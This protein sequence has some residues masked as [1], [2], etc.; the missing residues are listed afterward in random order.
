MQSNITVLSLILVTVLGLLINV[1]SNFL[2]DLLKYYHLIPEYTELKNIKPFLLWVPVALLAIIIGSVALTIITNVSS[3]G[4]T[5]PTAT[6]LLQAP[7]VNS[8]STQVITTVPTNEA[9]EAITMTPSQSLAAEPTQQSFTLDSIKTAA[10]SPDGNLVVTINGTNVGYVWDIDKG[11]KVKI[12]EGHSDTLKNVDFSP[13]GK[14]II[15]ISED[16]TA[17]IWETDTGK[18]MSKFSRHSDP[19]SAAMFHPSGNIVMSWIVEGRVRV[20]DAGTGEEKYFF[21]PSGVESHDPQSATYASFSPDGNLLAIGDIYGKI[22]LLSAQNG[23]QIGND[24]PGNDVFSKIRCITFSQDGKYLASTSDNGNIR[25]W[26]MENGKAKPFKDFQT[27]SKTASY[28]FFSP[29]SKFLIVSNLSDNKLSIDASDIFSLEMGTT[30]ATVDGHI[31]RMRESVFSFDSK[32]VITSIGNKAIVYRTDTGEV[33]KILEDHTNQ[34]S[35]AEFS[36]D[37]RFIVT[38]GADGIVFVYEA[39]G[40]KKF[41]ELSS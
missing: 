41:R 30:I 36:K 10:I 29:D 18:P 17:R 34:V 4:D 22:R 31:N 1:Y 6:Q 39:N 16:E 20:W 40:Y 33:D 23:I 28:G 26:T 24:F 8:T 27:K 32:L 15:T 9:V 12:L 38:A 2:Y 11:N 19:P 14:R 7:S 13:D 25:I 21:P 37:G 35:S 3:N 5:E